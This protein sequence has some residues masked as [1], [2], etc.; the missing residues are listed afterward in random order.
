[1]AVLKREIPAKRRKIHGGVKRRGL[2]KALYP[3]VSQSS[4]SANGDSP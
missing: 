1:M 3:R 4:G 2:A